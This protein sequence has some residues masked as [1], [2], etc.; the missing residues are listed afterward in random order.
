MTFRKR[1]QR[2]IAYLYKIYIKRPFTKPYYYLRN[3]Q[4]VWKFLN[5]HSRFVPIEHKLVKSLQENGYAVSH[6]DDFF[7]GRLAELEKYMKTLHRVQRRKKKYLEA[8]FDNEP[9]VKDNPFIALALEDSLLTIVNSYLGY[10]AKARG[11]TLDAAIPVGD[12]EFVGSQRW[13]RDPEDKKICKILLY[14]TDV[15]ENCG[16]FMYVKNSHYGGKWRLFP[17]KV[18][19]GVYPRAGEV[20][21]VIPKEDIKVFTGKKGTIIFC[22]TAGLH[23]GGNAYSK[24]RIMFTAGFMTNASTRKGYYR[25]SLG[26]FALRE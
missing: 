15:D 23:R 6:I 7:P 21:K 5:R 16:P 26:H 24:E 8:M 11:F 20:E 12:A 14:M 17:R 19:R 3:S 2:K 22:D 25:R 9:V 4:P 10:Y 1:L 13:H 18:P